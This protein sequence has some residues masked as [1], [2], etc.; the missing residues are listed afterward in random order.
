[1]ASCALRPPRPTHD[2]DPTFSGARVAVRGA[3]SASSRRSRPARSSALASSRRSMTFAELRPP[4]PSK[5]RLDPP[6]SQRRR[7]RRRARR[8]RRRRKRAWT[9]PA[10]TRRRPPR[11]PC[12]RSLAAPPAAGRASFAARISWGVPRRVSRS[13]QWPHVR[14]ASG[15]T[16]SP[17]AGRASCAAR[18]AW[19]VGAANAATRACCARSRIRAVRAR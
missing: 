12:L 8:R 17:T 16:I 13:A 2:L 18:R 9:T 14:R 19:R 1:M 5:R 3:C 6:S 4:M 11:R 7:R 10:S 15:A